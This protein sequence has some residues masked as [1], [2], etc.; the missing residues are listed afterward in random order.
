MVMWP[1]FQRSV[2]MLFTTGTRRALFGAVPPPLPSRG[3]NLPAPSAAGTCAGQPGAGD[4]RWPTP[5]QNPPR[6]P[7]SRAKAAAW[8]SN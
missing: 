7:A 4:F 8:A 1:T 6:I 5:T 2:G 3:E